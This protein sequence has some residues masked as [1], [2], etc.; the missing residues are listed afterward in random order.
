M[1]GISLCLDPTFKKISLGNMFD[2]KEEWVLSVGDSFRE[3][4]QVYKCKYGKPNCLEREPTSTRNDTADY[5]NF[6]KRKRRT[7]DGILISE[8]E[9]IRLAYTLT[10]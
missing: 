1:V 2:W 6:R 5:I 3:A 10:L 4:F 9:Y 7:A 8:E